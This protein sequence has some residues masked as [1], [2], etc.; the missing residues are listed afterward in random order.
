MKECVAKDPLKGGHVTIQVEKKSWSLT[1][2][3]QQE[4]DEKA[5]QVK[6]MVESVIDAATIQNI[7]GLE[8]MAACL[9]NYT[10]EDMEMYIRST[11]R[12]LSK[13]L[14]R[15]PTEEDRSALLDKWMKIYDQNH[16]STD[17]DLDWEMHFFLKNVFDEW[18]CLY[19]NK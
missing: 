1:K 10:D 4:Y 9:L 14:E 3:E 17:P 7:V 18:M 5:E 11:A 16:H 2:L 12:D 8:T 19:H 6:S 13:K 15:P